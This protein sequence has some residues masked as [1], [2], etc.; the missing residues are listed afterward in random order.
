M[1]IERIAFIGDSFTWGEGLELYLDTPTWK[2]QRRKKSSW[3]ELKDIQTPES[4]SFREKNRFANIVSDYYNCDLIINQNN[5]GYIGTIARICDDILT[6][7]TPVDFLIIQFSSFLRNPIHFHLGAW[8]GSCKCNYCK[9]SSAKNHQHI[10]CFFH[11]TDVIR[12]KYVMN[13]ELNDDDLFYLSW[14]HDE[15]NSSIF[16]LD[17]T[18][19][20]MYYIDI[21]NYIYSFVDSYSYLHLRYMIKKYIQPLESRG[22]KVLYIDSWEPLSSAVCRNMSDIFDRTIPLQGTGQVN[23]K[24]WQ[25]F[26]N[27][28][29]YPRIQHEF[30]KT[31]NG[32]PTL[33]QHKQIAKS[34]INLIDQYDTYPFK[35]SKNNII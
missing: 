17:T 2:S 32:H 20:P 25:E 24:S 33:I 34:I 27:S 30:P 16:D 7:K 1:K 21:I 11:F 22:T 14:L 28:F 6:Q 35:Y 4:I 12:K 8:E 3:L 15:F 9:G 10:H 19:N 18:D 5:G 13:E 29:K 23:T 26:E 31:E